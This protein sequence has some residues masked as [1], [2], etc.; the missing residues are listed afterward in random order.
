MVPVLKVGLI[1]WSVLKVHGFQSLVRSASIGFR[2]VYTAGGDT[3]I[4]K[5][6]A[7]DEVIDLLMQRAIQ[8]QLYY[9]NDLRDGEF[10]VDYLPIRLR[11]GSVMCNDGAVMYVNRY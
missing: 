1:C 8:T 3:R 11:P 4:T 5:D 9:L 6:W 10:I 7:S 2:S